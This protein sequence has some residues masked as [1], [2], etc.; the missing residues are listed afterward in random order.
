MSRTASGNR[1]I[2]T[3]IAVPPTT[4]NRVEQIRERMKQQRASIGQDEDVSLSDAFRK[5]CE[6][7]CDALEARLR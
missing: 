4:R 3:T 1:C 6:A 2:P 7:G 5:V